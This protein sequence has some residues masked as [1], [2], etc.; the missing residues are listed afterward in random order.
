M[1]IFLKNNLAIIIII[2]IL[3]SYL[4]IKALD[5]NGW[6]GWGFGS[7]QTLMSSQYWA[8]DGFIKNYL[9]FIPRPYSK[10]I[11][12]FDE[13]EFRN[14]PIETLN[15][16]L[17]RGLLYYT[18]YPPLYL[19]P[20]ALLTKIGFESRAAFRIFSLLVSLTALFLF[21]LFIKSISTPLEVA[22][23][24]SS[25]LA[26]SARARLLTGSSKTVAVIAS[27]YYG[28]SVTF[29]NYADSVSIQPW[30]ILFTFLILYLSVSKKRNNLA[31]WISYFALSLSSYDATFFV[32]AWLVLY[33]LIILKK[34]LWKK[35]LFWA[36]APLLGFVL[37][38][39]QNAWYL[40]WIDTWHDIYAS[41]TGRAIG[42][43]KGFI[44]GLITPF[45]SMASFQTVFIFK[46][47]V[48]VV[49]SAA[50]IFGILWK[51]RKKVGVDS[52][53]FRTVIILAIAA[54]SQP[55]FINVTGLWPYQGVLTAPFWGLL[56]GVSSIF[57]ANTVKQKS[58]EI[59]KTPFFI[60]L[61]AVTILFC[62]T[63]LYNTFVYA[64]DWPNNRPNQKVVDFSKV[65]KNIEPHSE[66]L[67]FRIIP[68]K[69]IWKSQF[70]TFNMEYY[71]GMPMID[72]ANTEDLMV[73][74]YWFQ[75]RSEYPFYSFIISENKTDVE[76][77]KQELLVKKV[78]NISP[79][80]EIQGQYLFTIGSIRN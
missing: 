40:G 78:K 19:V 45:V 72:F 64:K 39:L 25:G 29:L 59:L 14:R 75:N 79:I 18:H 69:P 49:T 13:P 4:G 62:S 67:A 30:T 38:I 15:G 61:T 17:A 53:Y 56:I 28:F 12:Y 16:E 50:I 7:A 8:K 57:M 54:A 77:V 1:V 44:L 22:S 43:L 37:Q 36:C 26:P 9:L 76:K 42:S 41:Y 33:D 46:K 80:T 51:L 35:W 73:D 66:R 58:W 11:H 68:K 24:R 63:Q 60:I 47:T 6:D 48:V 65:I 71:M 21:Y 3:G 2:L 23:P 32:F 74:F 5:E 31:I 52:N 27:I 70:P 20:Y 10:L 55:F 34:F